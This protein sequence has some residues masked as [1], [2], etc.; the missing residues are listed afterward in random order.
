[1]GFTDANAT[2]P[3]VNTLYGTTNKPTAADT[4]AADMRNNFA[5][6]MGI[7]RIVRK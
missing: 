4:Y 7:S 1:M 6:R 3:K 5:A 2:A